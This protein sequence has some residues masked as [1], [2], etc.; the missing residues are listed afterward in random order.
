MKLRYQ[1]ITLLSIFCIL[2]LIV[3]V[4]VYYENQKISRINDLEKISDIIKEDSYRF[5]FLYGD[6]LFHINENRQIPDWDPT[7]Y[8]I[9]HNIDLLTVTHPDEQILVNR[10]QE[11]LVHLNDFYSQNLEHIGAVKLAEKPVNIDLIMTAW[12]SNIVQN[13]EIITH[14]SQL[15]DIMNKES[16]QLQQKSSIRILLLMG[17][18]LLILFTVYF[19]FEQQIFR[20]IHEIAKGIKF[21]GS[22]DL[23]Y[24]IKKSGNDEIGDLSD[25]INQMTSNLNKITASM[26]ELEHEITKKVQVEQALR[27][28]EERF[29]RVVLGTNDGWWDWNLVN[30]TS[31]YSPRWWMMLGYEPNELPPDA[32]LWHRLLHPDDAQHVDTIL[33]AAFKEE[34]ENYEIEFRLAHK[35][36]HYVPVRSRGYITRN[37]D[38]TPVRLSGA[39]TDLTKQKQSE[40][41]LKNSESRFRRL[42]EAAK[43]GILIID[44]N[45]QIILQA[46]PFIEDLL[47]YPSGEMVGKTI[48]EINPLHPLIESNCL[49]GELKNSDN[50][51]YEEFALVSKT[52]V[53]HNVEFV[54]NIYQVDQ[55]KVIQC[56]VRDISDRVAAEKALRE[57]EKRFRYAIETGGFGVWKLDL[58]TG[59]LICSPQY[60]IIFGSPIHLSGWTYDLFLKR[61]VPDDRD[62][63]EHKIKETL[64]MLHDWD[65]EC[66]ITHSDGGIRWV[67]VKGTLELDDD[68]EPVNIFGLI[69]DITERKSAEEELHVLYSD[70]ENRVKERTLMLQQSNETLEEEIVQRKKAED[71]NQQTLSILN[72]TIESTADG[73]FVIDQSGDV[74][75]YNHQFLSLWNIP[76]SL[77]K[78]RDNIKIFEYVLKQV[79]NPEMFIDKIQDVYSGSLLDAFAMIELLDGRI[80]E[81]YSKP[82]KIGD[83]V[84]GRVWSFRDVTSRIQMENQIEKSLKEKE[85]LLKEI[86]HRVKNNMQVISSLLFMQ[87]RK[88]KDDQVKEILRESQNRIKS[89]AFV[90]EKIYQSKD[91]EQIDYNDYLRKITRHLF[92]S[93]LVDPQS[94]TLE[95]GSKKIFLPIDKAVPCSLIINELISNSIKYAFPDQRKGIIRIV[96]DQVAD[97]YIL[98]YSDN[99]VG[100]ANDID[101]GHTE[102]LGLEL[103]RG[104]IRQLNGTIELDRTNGTTYTIRF[105]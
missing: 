91:L 101:F 56:N 89:I 25:D 10:L 37:N 75:K 90:H 103:V 93:Y 9:S 22:G 14:A 13:Q 98:V 78:S 51:R 94:V 16:I 42:F 7:Y 28:S 29:K 5:S 34:L 59:N 58:N 61:V 33:N 55:T 88:A 17:V 82:K 3:G 71:T 57:S 12:S 87:A 46:N 67:W 84:A 15:S 102:T 35:D 21:I 2:I 43:D 73:I 64:L 76:Q 77:I 30:D 54:S 80:F 50:V 23:S 70:L 65:F 53:L 27:E 26:E 41:E 104:L 38:G 52:G 97:S 48:S 60:D 47:G 44:Y 96:F 79:K 8:K 11:D 31:Y 92:D 19:F 83:V 72:A 85:M 105:P 99:G 74:S 66:R 62:K 69:Q 24:Q 39:N 40:E 63:I 95:L 32:S 68:N 81:W 6:Y 100:M 18:F 49:F 1:F 86:H 4:S 45:S 20:S 36:G